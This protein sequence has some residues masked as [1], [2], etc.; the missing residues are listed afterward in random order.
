MNEGINKILHEIMETELKP[1]TKISVEVDEVLGKD[2]FSLRGDVK[3]DNYAITKMLVSEM[4]HNKDVR[5][6]IRW[7]AMASYM[8]RVDAVAIPRLNKDEEG[9]S[10]E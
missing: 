7:A 1:G 3:G 2:I 8:V 4:T 9:G 5:D 6:I 10:H